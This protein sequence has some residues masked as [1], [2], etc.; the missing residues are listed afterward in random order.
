[1]NNKVKTIEFVNILFNQFHLEQEE[2]RIADRL[3]TLDRKNLQIELDQARVNNKQSSSQC[4]STS[5]LSIPSPAQIHYPPIKYY[6]HDHYIDLFDSPTSH[7][8]KYTLHI[9]I[10]NLPSHLQMYLPLFSNLLFHTAINYADIHLDKY[11]FCELFN[12]DILAY[13]VSNGQASASPVQSSFVQ[14]HYMDTF[15]ITLQSACNEEIFRN[16]IDYFRYVL[17]GMVL[18]DY[19]IIREECEKQLKNLIEMLQDGQSIHQA[20]FNALLHSNDKKNYYHQMNI[21]KQKKFFEK[22]SRH[23]DKYEKEVV[24]KLQSI[25]RFLQHNLAQM[26]LTICGNVELVKK[27]WLIIDQFLAE[28]KI[29][30]QLDI[31]PQ[32]IEEIEEKHLH[33]PGTIIGNPHEESG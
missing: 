3:E 33:S 7:F 4:A 14:T 5:I 26:H 6:S 30:S 18:T 25:Q 12:R 10:A 22:I 23:P 11:P 17:F 24:N 32:P 31:D 8:N 19:K 27:H 20:Y 13:S 21:F 15:I 2:Q 29:K 16:T 28:V 9:P 1:M